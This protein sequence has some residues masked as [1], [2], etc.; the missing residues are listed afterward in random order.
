MKL[1][2]KDALEK[3]RLVDAQ[4]NPCG[5]ELT[6]EEKAGVA[7]MTVVKKFLKGTVLLKEG[8]MANT[9]YHIYEGCIRKYLLKDGEEKTLYFFTENEAISPASKGD[10]KPS[11]YYLECLEDV[12]VSVATLEQEQKMYEKFPR[13]QELCRISTEMELKKNQELF[14]T[15]M[16]ST[17][18]E[19]YINL[20][21]TR[22][23]L[24]ARVPQYQL[25]SYLG[26]TPISL[27]RIRKRLASK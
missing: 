14:A 21:K 5:P 6:E 27:S 26:V 10:A 12:T 1:P 8:Q 7:E 2:D 25:A 18:E 22:P 4:L 11:T 24:L 13:F 20:V 19:R 3:Q 16:S 15:F 9:C 23:D 17:P